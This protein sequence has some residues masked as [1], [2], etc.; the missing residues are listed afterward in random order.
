MLQ[1]LAH[2]LGNLDA[3]LTRSALRPLQEVG[4]YLDAFPRGGSHRQKVSV[5]PRAHEI[6]YMQER[7]I[8]LA[9]TRIFVGRSSA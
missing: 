1:R 3:P 7:D 2:Q 5:S 4:L 9:N 6:G 8:D